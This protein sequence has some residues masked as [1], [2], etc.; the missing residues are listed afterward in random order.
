MKREEYFTL[1]VLDEGHRF[2][3][4]KLRGEENEASLIS[5]C[6][7]ARD[8]QEFGARK[9]RARS[10]DLLYLGAH[11]NPSL[12]CITMSNICDTHTCIRRPGF[13]LPSRSAKGSLAQSTDLLLP[14][15]GRI[16]VRKGQEL[17]PAR[18]LSLSLFVLARKLFSPARIHAPSE[19]N[20]RSSRRLKG[21]SRLSERELREKCGSAIAKRR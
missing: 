6:A 5:Q 16:S 9:T 15:V 14:N 4:R 10:I 18:S 7:I 20:T 19:K 1:R 3:R 8:G 12:S 2:R 21:G 13:P 11:G 17:R